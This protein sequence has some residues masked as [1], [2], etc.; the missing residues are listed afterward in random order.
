MHT[1]DK[2]ILRKQQVQ[3]MAL[4]CLCYSGQEKLFNIA[5]L[6]KQKAAETD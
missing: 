6:V 5:T 1:R 4:L 2:A 3:N